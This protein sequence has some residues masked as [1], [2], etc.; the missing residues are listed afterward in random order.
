MDPVDSPDQ[1]KLSYEELSRLCAEL[2]DRVTRGISTQQ[3]L[4]S[5][6]NELDEELNRFKIIQDF[7]KEG[8]FQD[9]IEG[10]AT[11]ATEYFIQAFQQP[12]CLFAECRED[13][14]LQV[15]GQFG[16]NN[17]VIPCVLPLL[18]KDLPER[19]GFLLGEH[20]SFKTKLAFLQLEDALVAPMY[21]PDNSFY[22]LVVAG[23]QKADQRFYDPINPKDRHAFTVMATKASYLMYNFRTNELLKQE[24]RERRRMEQMLEA[25]ANDLLRSNAELEQ[26]AYVVSHD[27][28]APLRNV[29]GF[30]DLLRRDQSGISP[31]SREYIN[32]IWEEVKR[33]SD[34]IDALLRYARVS[35]SSIQ[36]MKEVDFQQ[37]VYKIEGQLSLTLQQRKAQLQYQ[38]LPTIQ[39]NYRQM[40]QLLQNLIINAIKFT[41][42]GRMPF[43]HLEAEPTQN[44]YRFA[45]KDNGIG[46]R[47]ADQKRIFGLFQR[48]DREQQFEGNG[49]GLSICKKIVEQH[50]GKIWVKSVGPGEGSTFFFTLPSRQ[51]EE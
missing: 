39:A 36:D 28:K 2:Q 18:S 31:A 3:Q 46:L 16:F 26:F 35:T 20:P 1:D 22:G 12:H 25:K 9:S 21:R 8:L 30:A 19:A 23:Q 48:A 13:G 32:M 47:P 29:Q 51:S 27:L 15:I 44:G 38:N 10:F 24:I 11:V 45:V 34:I 7:S 14:Q 43:I 50:K 5:I 40:Q 37:L 42:E 33:F 4:I 41:P 49:L 6:K 17:T